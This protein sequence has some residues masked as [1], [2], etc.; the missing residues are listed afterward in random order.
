MTWSG[1]GSTWAP[2]SEY[3]GEF[4]DGILNGLGTYTYPDGSKYVGEFKD[5]LRHGQGKMSYL[6]VTRQSGLWE[7]GM[8]LSPSPATNAPVASGTE[9]RP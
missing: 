2:G 8:Y 1:G 7:K 3:V 5:G 6:H 4:K 9:K